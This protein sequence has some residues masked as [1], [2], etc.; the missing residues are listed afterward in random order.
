MSFLM[1]L[2]CTALSMNGLLAGMSLDQSV[3][4]VPSRK[5]I[6]VG[7]FS[8]YIR[9]ADLADG[10]ALDAIFGIGAAVAA[11][12]FFV[13]VWREGD[14]PRGVLVTATA[15]AALSVLHSLLTARA[16]PLNFSQ[17]RYALSDVKALAPILDRFA[18]WQ[19]CRCAAQVLAFLALVTAVPWLLAT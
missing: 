6:G 9:A 14:A 18:I 3:K 7:A 4:Q 19:A 8:A 10:V 13:E 17:T 15:T 2:L 5:R 1:I 12:A 16:A 11:I